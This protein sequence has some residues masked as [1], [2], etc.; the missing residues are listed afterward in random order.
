[1]SMLS[2]LNAARKRTFN[3]LTGTN[4]L[5][6]I[7]DVNASI[8]AIN[9]LAKNTTQTLRDDLFVTSANGDTVT[10]ARTNGQS[11]AVDCLSPYALCYSSGTCCSSFYLC[12]NCKAAII[13]MDAVAPGEYTL[14]LDI[15]ENA[16]LYAGTSIIF[17]QPPVPAIIT[18]ERVNKLTYNVKVVALATGLPTA[19]LLTKTLL[20]INTYPSVLANTWLK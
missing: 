7:A 8:D 5:A 9:V 1:M 20:T 17:G 15:P 6:T 16:D 11:A 14:T 10:F 4:Q 13:K 3:L 2:Q 19:D 18:V 12:S